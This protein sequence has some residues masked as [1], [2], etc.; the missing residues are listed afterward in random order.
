M[1]FV[2]LILID[3]PFKRKYG[4]SAITIASS[5]LSEWFY[6]SGKVE[7]LLSQI[8]KEVD[9]KVTALKIKSM[10]K[11]D[12]NMKNDNI[13]DKVKDKDEIYVII[14]NFHFGPFGNIGSSRFPSIAKSYL[15]NVIV[16]H[17]TAT[18]EQ[19]LV[20]AEQNIEVL[21]NIKNAD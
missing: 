13:K 20:N 3:A 10:K 4:K 17:G 16:L 6:G 1:S 15:D 7:Q 18:H 2:S 11:K 5:F 21:E 9:I 19:N 12:S 8:G 14:P